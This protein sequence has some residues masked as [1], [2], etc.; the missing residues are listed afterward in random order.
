MNVATLVAG[1]QPPRG[2]AAQTRPPDGVAA[3]DADWIWLL[4]RG[5]DPAPT[6]LEELLKALDALAGLPEPAAIAGRVLAADGRLHPA[7][8]PWPRWGDKALEVAAAERG[9]VP[10]RAA[11]T[12]SLLVRADRAG[13]PVAR[14]LREDAGYL[15]PLS[16]VTHSAPPAYDPR[17]DLRLLAGDALTATERVWVA[18]EVLRRY[19]SRPSRTPRATTA[20]A[21]GAKRPR[22]R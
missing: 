2:L 21:L 8:L 9:L 14:L 13:T 5:A 3:A 4:G 18:I 16:V 10:I 6:A 7:H 20:S 15:A 19:R 17:G 12:A 22:R 11:S 1:D